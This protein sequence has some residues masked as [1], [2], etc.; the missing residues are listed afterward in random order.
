MF[1][2]FGG[3]VLV[4]RCW[5]SGDYRSTWRSPACWR[6]PSRLCSTSRTRCRFTG[7]PSS[8]TGDWTSATTAFCRGRASLRWSP[9]TANSKSR[10]NQGRRSIWDRGDTSHPIFGLGG[11]LSRM[12]PSIFLISATFYSIFFWWSLPVLAR[13]RHH[14][15]YFIVITNNLLD[16]T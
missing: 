3:L 6:V 2:R 7:Y 16:F 10:S 9:N 15:R 5:R 4:V 11:T 8:V 14:N 1:T 12:S 13:T